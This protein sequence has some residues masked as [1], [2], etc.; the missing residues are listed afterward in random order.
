MENE[1]GLTYHR[2]G[3]YLIPN[4][5]IQEIDR[6]VGKYGMLRKTYLKKAHPAK[7]DYL[8]LSEQLYPQLLEVDDQAQKMLDTVMPQL[9]KDV[10]ATEALKQSDPMKWVGLMNSCKA[11]VEEIIQ[12]ELIYK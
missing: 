11:Q 1:N 12:K 5:N 7:Y 8:L 2:E 4:I 9:A 3:D 10:G 6:E